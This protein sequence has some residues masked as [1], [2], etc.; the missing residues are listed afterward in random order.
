MPFG[1]LERLQSRVRIRLGGADFDGTDHRGM[2]IGK[3]AQCADPHRRPVPVIHDQQV[4]II[5]KITF[6]L[7]S[8]RRD[9][10]AIR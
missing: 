5:N 3:R 9:I 2:G 4:K 1:I 10:D 8:C 7:L 6:K